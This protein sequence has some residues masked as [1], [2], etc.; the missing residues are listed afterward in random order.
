MRVRLNERKTSAHYGLCASIWTL[1]HGPS[2][3]AVPFEPASIEAVA[4]DCVSRAHRHLRAALGVEHARRVRLAR[5]F[6]QRNTIRT[7]ASRSA[8]GRN[9][10]RFHV[11][12]SRKKVLR[13]RPWFRSV[14]DPAG[15]YGRLSDSKNSSIL[16]ES[17]S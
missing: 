2:A 3:I 15:I 8:Q 4:Q 16:G 6:F 17:A 10:S 5:H 7:A 1:L 11:A 12:L 13:S 14:D 9:Q